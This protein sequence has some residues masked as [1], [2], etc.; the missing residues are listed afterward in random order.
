MT[1]EAV[2]RLEAA[3]GR[4]HSRAA[5]A[6]IASGAAAF[7]LCVATGREQAALAALAASW[8]FFAGLSAGSLAVV[9]AVRLARGRWARPVLPFAEA[10]EGY[11]EYAL[12]LLVVLLAGAPALLPWAVGAGAVR[13]ALLAARELL[14]TVALVAAG[15]RLVRTGAPR[16][17]GGAGRAAV[18]YL[19]TY[20]V[21]LTFWAYDWVLSLSSAPPAAVLP[22][23]YFVGAFLSGLAWAALMAALRGVGGAK[24]RH[25]LGKLLFGFA[26]VWAY[27]LWALYLAAWYGGVPAEVAPLLARWAG[28]YR[29]VAIGVLVAVFL[30]PFTL[31]LAERTKRARATLLAGASAILVGLLAEGFLLVLPSLPL[32]ADLAAVVAGAA[33]T[34][35]VGGLFARAVGRRL[36]AAGLAADPPP[37]GWPPARAREVL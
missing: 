16:D 12:G 36:P 15:A 2:L 13:V 23:F 33:I 22:A 20:A 9:A 19:V 37:T 35:G 28:P 32:R 14:P 31:L 27:L 18:I 3:R 25:D 8:L 6:A 30:W 5:S 11:L 26:T 21:A 10:T 7:A 1:P 34:L 24:L 17:T 29:P 4:R